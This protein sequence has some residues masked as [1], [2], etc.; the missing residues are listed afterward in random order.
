MAIPYRTG[1]ERQ[2]AITARLITLVVAPAADHALL[3]SRNAIEVREVNS[4]KPGALR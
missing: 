2:Q 3:T 1:A 4:T